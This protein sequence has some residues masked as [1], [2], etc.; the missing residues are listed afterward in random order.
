[1]SLAELFILFL[2]YYSIFNFGTH[3]ICMRD[4]AARRRLVKFCDITRKRGS[5]RIHDFL[6]DRAL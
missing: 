5:D 3:Y 1:M 2:D 6:E 4:A